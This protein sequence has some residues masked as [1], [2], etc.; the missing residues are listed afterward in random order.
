MPP[1]YA[2][3]SNKQ[4]KFNP[5][6]KDKSPLVEAQSAPRRQKPV[7][8]QPEGRLPME[9]R[10]RAP[11]EIG[12]TAINDYTDG[13]EEDGGEESDPMGRSASTL[14]MSSHGKDPRYDGQQASPAS[15]SRKKRSIPLRNIT[16]EG[17]CLNSSGSDPNR[18]PT[19]A[20]P[21]NDYTFRPPTR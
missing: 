7:T 2:N 12:E 20:K 11:L 8:S 19:E 14:H 9:S 16:I 21:D 5:V 10:A 1:M 4:R 15:V 3:H 6:L 18:S 17:A 13:V